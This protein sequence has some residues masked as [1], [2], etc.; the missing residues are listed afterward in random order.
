[1]KAFTALLMTT[2]AAV[3]L[4]QQEGNQMNDD[5]LAR[6]LLDSSCGYFLQ[7][8]QEYIG[9]PLNDDNE[10][11][12]RGIIAENGI[13]DVDQIVGALKGKVGQCHDEIR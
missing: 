8:V 5:Q 7:S 2:V 13:Q 10:G 12:V 11:R 3:H 6:D 9:L 1:M 4:H